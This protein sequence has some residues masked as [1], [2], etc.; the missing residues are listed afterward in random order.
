MQCEKCGTQNKN[1]ALYC[2]NCGNA[3]E[4]KK[5]PKP[6][7]KKGLIIALGIIGVCA[8]VLGIFLFFFDY[9]N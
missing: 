1:G 3:L 7:K 9:Q 6:K 2:E 8:I 5:Q 4:M